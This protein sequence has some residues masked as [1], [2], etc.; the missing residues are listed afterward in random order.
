MNND[1]E[2]QKSIDDFFKMLDEKNDYTDD[3]LEAINKDFQ[4]EGEQ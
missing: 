2:L 1:N 4:N 3:Q